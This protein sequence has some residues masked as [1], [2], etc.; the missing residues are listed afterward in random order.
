L[1][2]S[3][4]F[5]SKHQKRTSFGSISIFM[6]ITTNWCYSGNSKTTFIFLFIAQFFNKWVNVASKTCINMKSNSEWL[7][8]LRKLLNWIIISITVFRTWCN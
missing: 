1:V 8:N 4:F 3:Q 5:I 7:C 6:W 2:I